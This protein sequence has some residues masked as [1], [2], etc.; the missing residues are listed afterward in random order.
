MSQMQAGAQVCI[1]I[2]VLLWGFGISQSYIGRSDTWELEACSSRWTLTADC[3]PCIM[4]GLRG[5]ASS[6][7]G[8]PAISLLATGSQRRVGPT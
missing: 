2:S 8:Y 6:P 3:A 5:P 1:H 7:K 4:P